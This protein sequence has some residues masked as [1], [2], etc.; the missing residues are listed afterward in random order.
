MNN[1]LP[2]YIR[3]SLDEEELL[4][5]Q[6]I[7]DG[8]N[9]GITFLALQHLINDIIIHNDPTD[10]GVHRT[11]DII[12]LE[13]NEPLSLH[14]LGDLYLQNGNLLALNTTG[15]SSTYLGLN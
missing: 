13:N 8:I 9:R 2:T 6:P 15:S 5:L 4:L 3:N 10:L 7:I 11:F 1:I 14:I 12:M